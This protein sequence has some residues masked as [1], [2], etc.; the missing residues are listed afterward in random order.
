MRAVTSALILIGIAAAAEAAPGNLDTSFSGD[1][2]VVESS[3]APSHAGAV[4]VQA[5]GKIVIAGST[6]NDFAVLR[7]H[8]NGTPDSSFGG[9]GLVVTPFGS[10]VSNDVANAV[11]IQANGRIVVAGSVGSTTNRRIGVVRYLTDGQRDTGFG[12]NGRVTMD[13]AP[14]G[15]GA[16]A[17]ALQP[18]GK[19]VLVG[20][21]GSDFAVARLNVDGTPDTS[22]GF[23]PSTGV[24]AR[25]MGSGS[26]S[27]SAVAILADG[28]IVLAGTTL[29]EGRRVFAYTMVTAGGLP[30]F[31]GNGIGNG[32]QHT[33]FG[34]STD[35]RTAAMAVQANGKIVL[36]GERTLSGGGGSVPIFTDTSMALARYNLDGSMDTTFGAGGVRVISVAG[37]VGGPDS[38]V[39]G[40]AVQLDGKIV[41]VGQAEPTSGFISNFTVLRLNANGALDPTFAGGGRVIT[42]FGGSVNGTANAVAVQP[43]DG[44]LVAV[45]SSGDRIALARYHAMTCNGL[46]VTILGTNGPDTITG[47]ERPDVIHGLA[48]NDTIDGRGGDDTICGGDGNDVLI[49]GAGNDTLIAGLGQDVL[50]GGA[51]LLIGAGGTDT[52]VGSNLLAISDPADTFFSCETINTGGAGVSGEW[53]AIEQHCNRSDRSPH[54]RLEGAL[55][56]FNPGTETTA[57]PSVV[58]F[59]LSADD[60]WDDGDVY[61]G[62]EE[63]RALGALDQ[64]LVELHWKLADGVD[65]T[66][67]R[68]IAVV[69]FLD[70]VSERNEANNLAVS[71]AVSSRRGR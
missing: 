10:S 53:L 51:P 58:A 43:S 71:P 41:V 45:G 31:I 4:A 25:D 47:T 42:D 46:D 57:V 19:I 22:F 49:G 39:R 70:A 5:D 62:R 32:A 23:P 3:L 16:A 54:C 33:S 17:M 7:Y 34:N 52:C 30:L 6:G 24:V 36:A 15:T 50:N 26:E 65:A 44:R 38:F 69:D 20:G 13:F 27:A 68:V 11:A 56:V 2:K 66:G 14:G 64:E 67:F 59:F 60:V 37:S 28:N 9:N 29:F 12:D 18:D 48:G 61:L 8:R 63:V 21:T 35:A 55:R 40:V 1:G